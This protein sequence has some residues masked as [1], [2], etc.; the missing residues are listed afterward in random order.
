MARRRGKQTQ[1]QTVTSHP[2]SMGG[3]LQRKCASCG[4]HT[5]AGEVCPQC[6]EQASL[7]QSS[8]EATTSAQ[9]SPVAALSGFNH[10]ISRVPVRQRQP[11]I[12]AKL[13]VG[14]P[15]DK[16]EQEADW[17]ADQIMRMPTSESM[18]GTTVRD[19]EPLAIQRLQ[20]VEDEKVRRQAE[21]ENEE[22]EEEILENPIQTKPIAGKLKPS[23]T[24][25][26]EGML[27]R[28][29]EEEAEEKLKKEEE[30]EEKTVQ[31]KQ[32]LRQFPV[33]PGLEAQLTASKRRGQPLSQDI[34]SFMEPRFGQDFSG[35]HVHADAN[36]AQLNRELGAQ[37]FT[38][39][40]DV[41][42][43]EG[44]Y[45]PNTSDG[46][47]LLAHEL[48][49]VIQQQ[50]QKV[51][52]RQEISESKQEDK[53]A[54]QPWSNT[55]Q[56]QNRIKKK[57][58]N[59][60]EK[61]NAFPWVGEIAGVWSAAMRKT[62]RKDP[63]KPHQNTEAD[64]PQGSKLMVIG[65]RG[66][67]LHV[68]VKINGVQ[69]TGYVSQELVRYIR[70]SVFEF[71]PIEIKVKIPSVSE[72]LVILKRAETQKAKVGTAYKP[73]EE[74]KNEIAL[75]ISVLRRT[76]KYAVN[77]ATYRVSFVQ[78]A[79]KQVE[80]TTI[81]DFILFVEQVERQYPSATPSEIVS[82]IRQLWFSDVNWEIL[83]SSEG[84]KEGGKHI[85]IETPPNPIATRFNMKTLAPKKGGKKL[86]TPLGTVDIGHVM[87]GIDA[88]LSPFPSIYPK[89]HLASRGHEDSGSKLK[90]KTLKAASGGD[91]R[92]FTTWAGDLGQ[93]YAEYL[94]ERFV[95]KKPTTLAKFMKKKAPPAELL[96][97]IHGY[98]A[99]Q[100]WKEVPASVSPSGSTFKI[101]N[102]LR[103]LYLVRGKSGKKYRQYM[104]KVSGKS[105]SKLKPFI[106]EQAKAFAR[107]WFAKKAMEA[108]KAAAWI[109]DTG[110]KT[111]FGSFS[112]KRALEEWMKEFDRVD[113]V[114]ESNAKAEEKLGK[115][116]D[117]FIAE[118]EGKVK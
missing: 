116:V 19:E 31:A 56:R 68:S 80:I 29:Y 76:G 44:M 59:S 82:E 78:A 75:A 104:E 42:F 94:V 73:N 27:Q 46:Q 41:F 83:V 36:S 92:D 110:R 89:S 8:A 33:T 51:M 111:Y 45:S 21:V 66:G 38:H 47:R 81:E 118:L 37:A 17:V 1:Q 53:L 64:L 9:G 115:V 11:L 23:I 16:Y 6:E 105:G 52:Q 39:G 7:S 25:V 30:E 35:V 91:S 60:K 90:Y 2:L 57:G 14:V 13:T 58:K 103:D 85:D 77:P 3:I 93:A 54:M 15:G 50:P 63:K 84:V 109:Y 20:H 117:D 112:K 18:E 34:L 72:S 40:Q 101:S 10:D 12:Q 32:K 102:V 24:P 28:Q 98:I 48:T 97:D 86:V 55:I 113:A 5:I 62:A 99:V 65:R 95:K 87:A 67:W 4:Q 100:V 70:S 108:T 114:C 74:Q 49:H 88:A 106:V 71:E 69:M 26:T 61:R 107:P 22:D 43:G 96:G 79:G